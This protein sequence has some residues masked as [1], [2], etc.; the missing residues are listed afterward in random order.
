MEG[1]GEEKLYC[2]LLKS[3]KCQKA[4]LGRV[5]QLILLA[6]VVVK[7]KKINTFLM[8]QVNNEQRKILTAEIRTS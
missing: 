7:R 3:G 5:S 1:M 6:I 4:P 2:P 8:N